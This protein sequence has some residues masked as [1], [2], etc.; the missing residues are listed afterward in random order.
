MA[1]ENER[2]LALCLVLIYAILLAVGFII[3]QSDRYAEV[4]GEL[5]A[6]LV[7]IIS[8][9]AMN[10]DMRWLQAAIPYPGFT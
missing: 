9:G 4:A 10:D 5:L 6:I 2:P 1:F 3:N 8:T 7:D